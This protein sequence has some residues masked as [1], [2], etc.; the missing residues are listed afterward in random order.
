MIH[1][2]TSSNVA[3]YLYDEAAEQLLIGYS[4]NSNKYARIYTYDRVP[5]PTYTELCDA[6]SKGEYICHRIAFNFKYQYQGWLEGD[7]IN[8]T[9]LQSISDVLGLVEP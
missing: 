3:G 9:E 1:I 6:T 5:S 2:T 8:Y 7:P 4:D